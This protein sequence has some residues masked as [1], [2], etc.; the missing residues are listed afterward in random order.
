MALTLRQIDAFRA[1]MLLGTL[2]EAAQMLGI[3]QPAI[4]RLVADLEEEIGFKLF[5]RAGRRV[6]PTA[7]AQILIEE[8]K[9][10]LVGLDQIRETAAS[11]SRYR[12]SRLRITAVPAI[13][14]TIAVDLISQFATR[15]P[16]TFVALEVQHQDAA[17]DSVVALQCDLGIVLATPESPAFASHRLVV[18]RAHCILPPGH[19]LEAKSVIRPA[20]LAE[21]AFVSLGSDSLYRSKI[22][23]IF[24]EEGIERQIRYEGRTTEVVCSMVAAGLGV[25]I[26]GP[27][28]SSGLSGRNSDGRFIIRPFEPAPEVELAVIWSTHRPVPLIAQEFMGVVEEAM[29]DEDEHGGPAPQRQGRAEHQDA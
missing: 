10:A 14:S 23:A 25:A 21:E 8:V 9:R 13:A 24:Q 26:V 17:I 19:R 12:Y 20:D 29:R 7:E 6:V 1:V 27:L 18:G 5:D 16:E 15:F 4:S 11:I 22:E 2:T 28:Q 3:S